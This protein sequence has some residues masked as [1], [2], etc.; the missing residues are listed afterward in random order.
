MASFMGSEQSLTVT[1]RPVFAR[2]MSPASSSTSRCFITAGSL[3]A[4]GLAS[5]LTEALSWRASRA[6]IARLVGSARAAKV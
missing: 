2:V 5:S 4:N 6:R 1:V 3:I